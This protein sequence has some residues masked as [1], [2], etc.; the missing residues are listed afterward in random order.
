V[1]TATPEAAFA[2][3]PYVKEEEFRGALFEKGESQP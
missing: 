3:T 2:Y 1:A